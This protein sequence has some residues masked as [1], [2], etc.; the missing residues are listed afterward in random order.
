MKAKIEANLKKLSVQKREAL[1]DESQIA[2]EDLCND[3]DINDFLYVPEDK[4]A[5]MIR[6]G[7]AYRIDRDED[8]LFLG[9]APMPAEDDENPVYPDINEFKEKPGEPVTSGRAQ[10]I[11]V[12]RSFMDLR[13]EYGEKVLKELNK[14]LSEPL[15]FFP[16]K[17]PDRLFFENSSYQVMYSH[18]HPEQDEIIDLV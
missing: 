10:V 6:K 9:D 13:R 7:K 14:G 16:N 18:D 8:V 12:Y 3:Q 2:L 15:T 1:L 4:S 11:N 5:L 17:V